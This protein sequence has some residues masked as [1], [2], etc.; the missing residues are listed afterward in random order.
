MPL[1]M[2]SL[3][4]HPDLEYFASHR[5]TLSSRYAGKVVVI[6][7]QKVV[8]IYERE[9]VAKREAATEF[10]DARYLIRTIE[11]PVKSQRR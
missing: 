10:P 2:N 6:R 9:D 5:E 11:R 8:R 1:F 3:S 4:P 7:E